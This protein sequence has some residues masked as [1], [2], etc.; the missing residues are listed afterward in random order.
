MRGQKAAPKKARSS[1]LWTGKPSKAFFGKPGNSVGDG[2]SVKQLEGE[3]NNL[4]VKYSLYS[5]CASMHFDCHWVF[6]VFAQLRSMSWIA[7]SL[8]LTVL[9]PSFAWK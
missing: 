2:S 6:W 8:S 5:C 7:L 1:E 9:S 4:K 3:V